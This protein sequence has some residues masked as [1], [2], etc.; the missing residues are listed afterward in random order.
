[1]LW[2]P[3]GG[4]EETEFQ[5]LLVTPMP[6]GKSFGYQKLEEKVVC[7]DHSSI[8]PLLNLFSDD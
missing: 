7:S 5:R 4:D 3:G 1:M 8:E 2:T 6:H